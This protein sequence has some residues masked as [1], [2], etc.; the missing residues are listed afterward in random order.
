MMIYQLLAL[1]NFQLKAGIAQWYI[2]GLGAA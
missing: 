1:R 2:A